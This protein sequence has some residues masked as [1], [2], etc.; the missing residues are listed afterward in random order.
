[1]LQEIDWGPVDP[2]F[3]DDSDFRPPLSKWNLIPEHRL[4][5]AALLGLIWH[6]EGAYE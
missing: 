4:T 5:A 1:M 6:D 3:D 2:F